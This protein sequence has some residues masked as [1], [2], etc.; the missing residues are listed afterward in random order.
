M[1]LKYY[2][3]DP[4]DYFGSPEVGWDT[5]LKI[6]GIQLE[7]ISEIKTNFF[8]FKEEGKEVFLVLVKD[9]VK[10]VINTLNVTIVVK[11]VNLHCI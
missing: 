3:L 11:K 8:L 1:C 9:I 2:G 7:L 6:T 10:E 4:C 5:M